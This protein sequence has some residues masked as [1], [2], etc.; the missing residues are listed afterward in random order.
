MQKFKNVLDG[1]GDYLVNLG[2]NCELALEG[3]D[4]LELKKSKLYQHQ[5]TGNLSP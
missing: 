2:T 3:I 4:S 1:L 5:V